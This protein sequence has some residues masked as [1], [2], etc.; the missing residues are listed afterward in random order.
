MVTDGYRTPAVE[1]SAALTAYEAAAAAHFSPATVQA[2]RTRLRRMARDFADTAPGDVTGEQFTAWL[3][4]LDCGESVRREYL[5]AARAFYRWALATGITSADPVPA[6]RP[7]GRAQVPVPVAW[8]GPLDEFEAAQREAGIAPATIRRRMQRL[9]QFA[10]HRNGSP[11]QVTAA[12]YGRWRGAS[13]GMS[14]AAQGSARDALHAFYGWAVSAGRMDSDPTARTSAP[15]GPRKWPLP[16]AWEPEM[17]AWRRWLIASDAAQTTVHARLEHLALFARAFPADP[18]AITTEQIVDWMGSHDWA[19]ESKRARRATLRTFYRWAQESG[20]IADDPTARLPRVRAAEPVAR[21]ATESE[22]R[23]ALA[24]ARS[25]RWSLALRLSCELGMRRAE[26][27]GAR[28]EDLRDTDAGSWLVVRGKGG[29]VRRLPV[30]ES[31]AAQIREC[32]PGYLFPSPEGGH[33]TPRWVGTAVGRLLPEGVTMHML[34]HAFATR[35]YNVNHDVFAVQQLLGHASAATTQRY[36][37]VAD[38]RLRALVE[39][40]AL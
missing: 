17:E 16:P 29:K 21:P 13:V 3:A 11:W 15:R 1:W 32:D 20:R 34:R 24:A 37:Q 10:A 36:V 8:A 26:V 23:A 31:L 7:A 35:A 9:R 4:G 38:S 12:E 28:R 33:V 39:A 27:A 30:P 2:R 6:P 40:V 18:Y 14:Q 19:R 25:P 22:Y 5:E